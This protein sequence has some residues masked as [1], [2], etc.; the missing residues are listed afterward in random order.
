M[1]FFL[2]YVPLKRVQ[3]YLSLATAFNE[4]AKTW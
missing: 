3:K 2:V 4:G 1:F